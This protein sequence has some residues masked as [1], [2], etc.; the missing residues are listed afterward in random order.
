MVPRI[1]LGFCAENATMDYAFTYVLAVVHEGRLLKADFSM[2]PPQGSVYVPRHLFPNAPFRF[3]DLG[4]WDVEEDPGF[5]ER[6]RGAKYRAFRVR[7]DVP[8]E[9]IRVD[10]PSHRADDVRHVLLE[11]GLE[12][13][14]RL[15]GRDL[16][17]EFADGV[18]AGP[19]HVEPPAADGRY[20]CD[21][22]RLGQPVG[23]WPNRQALQP[24]LVAM[25]QTVRWFVWPLPRPDIFLDLASTRQVLEGLQRLGISQELHDDLIARLGSVDTGVRIP[26]LHRKRLQTL[27]DEA[28]QTGKQLEACVPLL[29][30]DPQVQ[31]A[32]E[33]YKHQVGE[34][35]RNELE[36]RKD[37]LNDELEALRAKKREVEAEIESARGRLAEEEARKEQT[38]EATAEAVVARARRAQQEVNAL[39]A[40]VAVL[41]P[42]MVDGAAPARGPAAET[43]RGEAAPLPD[44]GAAYAHLKTQLENVG[45]QPR[46]ASACAR[47]VLTALSLGQAVFF[48]GSLAPVLARAAAIALSGARWTEA[49][50]AADLKDNAA[51]RPVVEAVAAG[52][53]PAALLLHGANRSCIDAYGADLVRLLAER[54]AGADAAPGLMVLG[55][56]TEGLSAP[57][58]DPVLTALGPIIHTDY[59]AWKRGWKGRPP[60][61]GQMNALTWPHP[62]GP[63]EEALGFLLGELQPAPN[64]L[65]RRNVLAADRRLAGWPGEPGAP[66]A[67]D[68]VAFA[69]VL[70]RCLAAG[71]DL[72]EHADALRQL[73]PEPDEVDPRLQQLLRSH[74]AAEVL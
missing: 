20:R 11:R 46:S 10:C 48:Q 31:E 8:A 16:L 19:L 15:D 55:V 29:R 25:G 18:T 21:P 38:A 45:L 59:L 40:D 36:R 50:V 2:F 42:F 6:N 43:H 39:L 7:T 9:L 44:L 68:S 47:E 24:V 51:F 62:D 35:H 13:F 70:P 34:E 33:Q 14:Y 58:P 30:A 22:E 65:W 67:L 26:P 4:F 1:V 56:L 63:D 3:R 32:L 53:A 64:E 41:R 73:F 71:V 49:D 17:L 74:G 54:A 57:P 37:E 72:T 66:D 69:W 52:G 12:S 61:P 28:L 5:G 60:R 27:L 23:A